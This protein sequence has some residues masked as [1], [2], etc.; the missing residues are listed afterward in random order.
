M[1]AL[2]LE[3]TLTQLDHL[4][5]TDLLLRLG[6]GTPTPNSPGAMRD[7]LDSA[8]VVRPDTLSPDVITMNSQ[9]L[10]EDVVSR[11][12]RKLTL[13][14][15]QDAEPASGFISVL[16]PVGSSLLGLHVG[17]TARWRTPLGGTGA[18]EVIAILFQ[19]ESVG[20]YSL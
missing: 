19:P 14:Y 15:P 5:L 10:V 17:A 16:S 4:R 1:E 13:C 12:A 7:I 6:D 3:R 11:R 18:A 9:V 20:D 8:N 2:E